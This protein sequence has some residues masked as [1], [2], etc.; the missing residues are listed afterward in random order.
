[1]SNV[2]KLKPPTSG[3]G[4]ASHSITIQLD[5]EANEAAMSIIRRLIKQHGDEDVV[6]RLTK[7][8][9]EELMKEIRS[10]DGRSFADVLDE[11]LDRCI[12]GDWKQ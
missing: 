8:E 2:I 5:L 1:M 12:G 11:A 7:Q 6:D 10:F 9:R 3:V 4:G